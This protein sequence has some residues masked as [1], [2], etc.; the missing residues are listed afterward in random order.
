MEVKLL[1]FLGTVVSTTGMLQRNV[2][3]REMVLQFPWM[4]KTEV[5]F[6]VKTRGS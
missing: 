5:V 3:M 4:G 1:R 2:Y 6:L